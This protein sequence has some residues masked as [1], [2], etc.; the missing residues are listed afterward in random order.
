MGYKWSVIE[1]VGDIA[2]CSAI[3]LGQIDG[4][5]CVCEQAQGLPESSQR[6]VLRRR[7][8]PPDNVVQKADDPEGVEE[9]LGLPFGL[10]H[11]QAQ[12]PSEL[13]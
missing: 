11:C 3:Q 4:A 1:S 7:T 9:N 13:S 2:R 12:A 8:S 5:K 10:R 6:Q